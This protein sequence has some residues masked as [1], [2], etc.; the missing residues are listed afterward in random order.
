MPAAPCFYPALALAIRISAGSQADEL[1]SLAPN[2]SIAIRRSRLGHR[3]LSVRVVCRGI[4]HAVP[5]CPGI[6]EESSHD[7]P[8]DY[9]LR[10]TVTRIC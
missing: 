4:S 6:G 10:A 9:H 1:R 7:H 2:L 8:L 5:T 3:P